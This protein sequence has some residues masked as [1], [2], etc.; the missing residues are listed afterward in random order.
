ML[1]IDFIDRT[2]MMIEATCFGEQATHLNSVIEVGGVYR[3]ARCRIVE[4]EYNKKK[5]DKYAR[6]NLKIGSDSSILA[7]PDFPE[8]PY[9]SHNYS[10][11]SEITE[12]MD[13]TQ[14]YS[15]VGILSK[16]DAERTIAKVDK[17]IIMQSFAIYDPTIDRTIE[18]LIWNR[19]IKI[20]RDLLNKSV[21]V[22][23]VKVSKY[24]DTIKLNATFKS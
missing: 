24:K 6:Y 13:M 16:I 22:K 2:S 5:G 19:Q 8:I 3:I 12:S 20:D 23:N 11:L 4:D 14:L 1:N 21:V 9:D 10:R 7:V 18:A 17:E 15:F